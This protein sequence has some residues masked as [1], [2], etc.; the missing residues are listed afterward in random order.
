MLSRSSLNAL[1]VSR[2]ACG[3]AS[4]TPLQELDQPGG[5]CHIKFE[6]NALEQNRIWTTL[7]DSSETKL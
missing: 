3:R 7:S 4:T 5:V 1:A 6:V 2:I